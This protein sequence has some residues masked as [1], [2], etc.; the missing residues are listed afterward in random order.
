ML[1][2]PAETAALLRTQGLHVVDALGAQAGDWVRLRWEQRLDAWA[3]LLQAARSGDEAALR[4]AQLHG[5]QRIAGACR[6]GRRG[7]GCVV[8]S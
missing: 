2:M 3:A 6:A 4:V 7:R 5:L 8:I 1:G